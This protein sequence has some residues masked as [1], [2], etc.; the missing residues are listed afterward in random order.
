MTT[1]VIRARDVTWSI[2]GH[3]IIEG[4]DL[5]AHH[6]QMLG[7]LG[8]N[9]SGKTSFL[10]A[11]A[12]LRT[13]DR[14]VV[15]LD[16]TDIHTIPRRTLARRLAVVE[17]EGETA[18]DLTLEQVVSLGRTPFHGRFDGL[19]KDDVDIIDA[20]LART[21]LSHKR[22]QSWNTLSGGER[23]RGQLARALAQQPSEIVLD[24]PTNHLDIRHQLDLLT[25]LRNLDMTVVTALHDL[26]LAAQFCDQLVILD[27]GKVVAAGPP[28]NVLT[29]TLLGDV[30]G[31]HAVVEYSTHTQS[32]RITYLP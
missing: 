28:E 30:Y 9:G 26:N 18:A 5:D 10:R 25:L 21:G 17:Q 19:D 23:Q 13:L 11:L 14:G 6:G 24:E 12:G 16:G 15:S 27:N 29:P 4:I 7:V 8:P 31:V 20:A 22:S 1:P 2:K 32:I 3:S